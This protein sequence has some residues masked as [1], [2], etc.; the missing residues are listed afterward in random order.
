MSSDDGEPDAGEHGEADD[1]DPAQ[2]IVEVARVKRATSQV[3]AEDADGLADHEAGDDA[4]R[5]RVGRGPAEPGQPADGDAGREEREHRDG[6]ARRERPEPVL[7][8]LGQPG[9]ASGRRP[10]RCGRPG[11]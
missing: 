8:V 11:R 6:E 1:V 2:V 9:P 5:D 4:E 7:E 10:R 3:R